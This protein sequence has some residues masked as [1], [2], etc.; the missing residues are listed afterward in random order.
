[1]RQEVIDDTA[2]FPDYT[3]VY[4]NYPRM[5]IPIGP[6]IKEVRPQYI[7]SEGS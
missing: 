2:K 3:F 5:N 4:T 6:G 1:V 7:P